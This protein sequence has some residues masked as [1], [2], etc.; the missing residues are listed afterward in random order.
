MHLR[1]NL[2]A[3]RLAAAAALCAA[4]CLTGC[5]ALVAPPP[6][7][8]LEALLRPV[9]APPDSVTLEI[10]QA[11]IPPEMSDEAE[12]LWEQL[13]EQ[14]FDAD[15]RR[16]LLANG[17]RAGLAGGS[18]PPALA[19]LLSLKSEAPPPSNSRLITSQSAAPR[20][21][22]QVQQL[23]RRKDLSLQASEVC[24]EA[25]V[26]LSEN[27]AT[28]GKTFQQV[29]GVYAICAEPRPG[30]RV[31]LRITPELHHGD[32]RS[33][34]AGS[35]EQGIFM[36]TVSREREVYDNL[37]MEA[38]LGP[39]EMLVL[40][41]LPDAQAS[42]GGVFHSAAAGGVQQRKLI[43]VRLLRAPASEILAEE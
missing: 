27:G 25:Q 15:L 11:R 14:C 6:E 43:V 8:A 20:A 34:R 35:S 19:D 9:S 36:T 39:G 16:R 1:R 22:R 21:T 38:E 32:L 4:V 40:G 10:F 5:Q 17:F 31:K 37:M 28:G 33:R 12:A 29:Q 23:S 18:P 24:D 30:Q 7:S 2:R 41:S 26:L 42:L 3:S 13:D